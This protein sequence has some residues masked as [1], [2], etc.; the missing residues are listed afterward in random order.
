MHFFEFYYTVAFLVA[1]VAST[2]INFGLCKI[3]VFE[4]RYEPLWR[5]WP[6]RAASSEMTVC[7]SPFR[8]EAGSGRI[9]PEIRRLAVVTPVFED[10]VC[11]RTL[12]A[13][14]SKQFTGSELRFDVYAIDDC[15]STDPDVAGLCSAIPASGT[16]RS[17]GSPSISA[18]SARSR[19]A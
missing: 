1:T 7:K 15:S 19:S 5:Y 17:C 11:P 16:S 18:S 8:S 6:A 3:V 14:I 13:E 9:A 10:W 2:L 4:R 12:V